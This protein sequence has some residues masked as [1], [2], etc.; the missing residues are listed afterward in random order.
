MPP[1]RQKRG[2]VIEREV[3]DIMAREGEKFSKRWRAH[4]IIFQRAIEILTFL[5]NKVQPAALV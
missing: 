1:S 5:K 4:C 3:L 2:R